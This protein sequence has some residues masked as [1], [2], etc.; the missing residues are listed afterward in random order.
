MSG[1]R[2]RHLAPWPRNR[3]SGRAHLALVRCACNPTCSDAPLVAASG[4]H[5]S[6]AKDYFETTV[7]LSLRKTI[8]QP[9][10][11]EAGGQ[12]PACERS[13]Q[14]QEYRTRPGRGAGAWG[15]SRPTGSPSLAGSTPDLAYTPGGPMDARAR[16]GAIHVKPDRG[17][18]QRERRARASLSRPRARPRRLLRSGCAAGQVANRARS[19]APFPRWFARALKAAARYPDRLMLTYGDKYTFEPTKVAWQTVAPTTQRRWQRAMNLT[20]RWN[21]L[22]PN[23]GTRLFPVAMGKRRTHRGCALWGVV[24]LKPAR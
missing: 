22:F 12:Q 18:W 2:R 17:G 6:I 16:R 21:V 1:S 23:N 13:H 14:E 24:A 20:D 10:I 7:F 11:E 8:S 9:W 3:G 15:T 5:C 19:P 4:L